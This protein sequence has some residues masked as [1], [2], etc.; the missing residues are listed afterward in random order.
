LEPASS[1]DSSFL[2]G[3]NNEKLQLTAYLPTDIGQENREKDQAMS[4]ANEHNTQEHSEVENVENL[5][6]CESQNNYAAEL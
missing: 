4:G 3:L 1:I 2:V 5:R 6:M